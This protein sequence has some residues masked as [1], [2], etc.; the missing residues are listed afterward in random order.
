MGWA[1]G[2]LERFSSRLS[3][4]PY[5]SPRSPPAEPKGAKGGN[6]VEKRGPSPRQGGSQ[7]KP[8]L[9]LPHGPRYLGAHGLPRTYQMELLQDGPQPARHATA[10]GLDL[11]LGVIN[12]ARVEWRSN[13]MNLA[14]GHGKTDT[15][16]SISP[17]LYPGF[18]RPG[19]G[20]LPRLQRSVARRSVAARCKCKAS[21]QQQSRRSVLAQLPANMR[22]PPP[23]VLASWPTP[24]YINP[25]TRGP[26]LIV[27]EIL[28]LCIGAIF[29]GLRM[30]VRLRIMRSVD[31]DDWLMVAGAVCPEDPSY[32][33]MNDGLIHPGISRSSVS[34]SRYASS[35]PLPSTAGTSMSG[36]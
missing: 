8:F 24:N 26:A 34:E 32:L 1:S 2:P 7:G 19:L 28:A 14:V 13:D 23:D 3:S 36:T 5:D 12:G 29:L 21:N 4:V 30:Y 11:G 31:W 9:G 15:Q 27:V 20:P 6:S 33:M 16:C 25:V 17:L 35:W 10:T 18:P 22:S